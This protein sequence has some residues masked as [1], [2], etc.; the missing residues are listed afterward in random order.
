M[1]EQH[2]LKE[3][4]KGTHND[5]QQNNTGKNNIIL[6]S[7]TPPWLHQLLICMCLLETAYLI[8]LICIYNSFMLCI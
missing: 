7:D 5:T 1:I 6:L 8:D 3:L 2:A 4:V